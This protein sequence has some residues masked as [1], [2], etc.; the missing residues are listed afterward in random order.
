MTNE[1]F[2]VQELREALHPIWRRLTADRTISIGKVGILGYLA[3]HG[4]TTASTLAAAEKISPQA[5]TAA[6]QEMENLGLLVRTIDENDRR[7]IWIELTDAGRD[8]LAAER[9]SGADWLTSAISRRLTSD[10]KKTLE[11]VI[12]ILQK[13]VDDAHVD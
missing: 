10:E 13:L 7:R 6:V 8:R 3:K 4:A 12:P 11:S 1:Q 9:S 5:I 2:P